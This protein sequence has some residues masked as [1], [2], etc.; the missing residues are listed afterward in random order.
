MAT[1]NQAARSRASVLVHG[2]SGTGKGLI[3]EHIHR[4]SGP[5]NGIFVKINC[6]AIP[7]NLLEAELFGYE[8]GAFTGASRR[9]KGRVELAHLGTLFLDEIGI[10]PLAFQTKLLRFL[11]EGEFERLG[12]NE[13]LRVQT[14]VISATNSDLPTAIRN[15]TFREDLYYRLNVIN[16]RVPPLR[17]RREDIALL[18]QRFI[19]EAAKKNQRPVPLIHREA[20]DCLLDY[21]WPGNI[22]ELQN[23][24]ERMVVM[25]RTGIIERTDLPVEIARGNQPRTVTIPLGLSL[26]QVEKLLMDEVLR[27]SH[28]DKKQAAKL[29]GIHPRTIHRYLES[30]EPTAPPGD[31]GEGSVE[32][33]IF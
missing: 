21:P 19:E 28:G 12:S 23:L 17:E 13:T 5:G 33:G 1:V 16:I 25:N 26:R 10:A 31:A 7:E 9:K 22:R 6:A 11:Q 14:R 15:G 29:L 27:L 2:E 24:I 30:T 32:S 18:A 4:L 8:A 20:L 3:A